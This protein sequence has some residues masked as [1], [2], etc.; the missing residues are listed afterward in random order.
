M[1]KANLTFI[2][3]EGEI[4]LGQVMHGAV[5]GVQPR[6]GARKSMIKVLSDPLVNFVDD[7]SKV[8]YTSLYTMLSPFEFLFALALAGVF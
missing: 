8:N 1:A 2:A 6:M 4:P 3:R 5:K 7:V